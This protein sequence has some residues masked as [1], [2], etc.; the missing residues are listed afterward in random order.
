MGMEIVRLGDSQ[1]KQI[2]PA[3]D[4]PLAQLSFALHAV[5]EP[6]LSIWM[7]TATP[8]MRVFPWW[9]YD[10]KI[11]DDVQRLNSLWNVTS[12]QSLFDCLFLSQLKKMMGQNL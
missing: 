10:G 7:M 6:P 4:Q 2:A 11:D 3:N 8:G 5:P 12:A 1:S 9:T